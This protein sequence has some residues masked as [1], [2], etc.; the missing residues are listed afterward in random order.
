MKCERV[1]VKEAAQILGMSQQGVREYMKR[2]LFPAPIG[3][4]TK[5]GKTHQYHI[6]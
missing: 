3:Y 4:V 6:Y 1:S 2:D 5:V